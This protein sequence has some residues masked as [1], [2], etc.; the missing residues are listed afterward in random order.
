MACQ[1][2][3]VGGPACL[4]HNPRALK[5]LEQHKTAATGTIRETVGDVEEFRQK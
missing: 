5:L 4:T 1:N 2:G 3:C